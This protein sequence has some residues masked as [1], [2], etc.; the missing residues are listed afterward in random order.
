[1]ENSKFYK[2]N[3]FITGVFKPHHIFLGDEEYSRALDCLV[4][5]CTDIL[6]V[7]ESNGKILL[8]KRKVEPQPDWWFV[9]GKYQE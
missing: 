9:G 1:M 2:T 3:H 7:D 5:A 4:K 6:L 8:G